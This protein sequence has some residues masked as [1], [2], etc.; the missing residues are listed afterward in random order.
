MTNRNPL[1]HLLIAAFLGSTVASAAPAPSKGPDR[2]EVQNLGRGVYAAIRKEPPGLMFDANV[3]F[4]VNDADVV[5]VDTNMTPSSA[6]R[7][8]AALRKITTKPVR[9]VVNTHWHDDHITGNQVY[10]KAFPG[11]EFIGQATTLEDEPTVGATNRKGLLKDGPGFAAFIRESV[12]KGKSLAG[13]DLTPEERTAYLSDVEQA[14]RYFQEAPG[15]TIVPPT[16]VVNDRLTIL[17]GERVI[18]I[19]SLGAAHTRAD[20][21]VHLPKDGILVSGDLVVW[22]IPLV[23]STSYPASYAGALTRLLAL[24][25][26]VLVPGHG[27]VLRDNGYVVQVQRLLESLVT[28]TG[29]AVSRGETLEQARKSVDL[30]E[31]RKLFAADSP[32]LKLIFDNY[33]ASPGVA[34]A[35]QELSVKSRP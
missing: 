12:Q 8:L 28:Q 33:V 10:R 32:Q 29:A 18:D 11:V 30:T 4:I 14:E 5:V 1:S 7:V 24:G 35:F 3:V 15:V 26:E 6:T 20:L 22:P 19:L 27:P 31:Y 17:R 21:V 25:H 13:Q 34:A 23:G 2:F 16:I 9:Y